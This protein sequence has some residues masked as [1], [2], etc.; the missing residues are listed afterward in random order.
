[1]VRAFSFFILWGGGVICG[2]LIH[3]GFTCCL[4]LFSSFFRRNGG[5][6]ENTTCLVRKQQR[7]NATSSPPPPLFSENLA[8][9][10]FLKRTL[11]STHLGIES[12]H[13]G[14]IG[15]VSGWLLANSEQRLLLFLLGLPIPNRKDTR[16]L[17]KV[18]HMGPCAPTQ[19]F[20][21]GTDI[22]AVCP[23]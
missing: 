17:R 5:Q 20:L 1:M 14:E 10:A 4:F 18:I 21:H 2:C 3:L 7:R 6:L 9:L 22:I 23:S 13:V 19:P 11:V 15:F 16:P 12:L 8:F